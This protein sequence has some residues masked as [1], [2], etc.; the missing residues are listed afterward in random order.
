[1]QVKWNKLLMKVAVW[2]TAE[3][4]LNFLGLDN[5]ADYSEFLLDNDLVDTEQIT[6]LIG[7]LEYKWLPLCAKI[8][9][10]ERVL[11]I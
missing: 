3:I 11:L 10:L 4:L 1:M 5:I 6:I 9:P 7:D 2:L 8:L